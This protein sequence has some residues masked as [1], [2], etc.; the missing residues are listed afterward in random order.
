M[1]YPTGPQSPA[2]GVI[3]NSEGFRPQ[4][5]LESEGIATPAPP[6]GLQGSKSV[7]ET[8]GGR[9]A[10]FGKSERPFGGDILPYVCTGCVCSQFVEPAMFSRASFLGRPK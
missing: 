2:F 8:G 10:T 9:F 7:G 4:Q 3:P 6:P 5:S 1:F